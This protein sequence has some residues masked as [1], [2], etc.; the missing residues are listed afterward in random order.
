VQ[1]LIAVPGDPLALTPALS[2]LDHAAAEAAD[3]PSR[4]AGEGGL[5]LQVDVT[6]SPIRSDKGRGPG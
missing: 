4:Q 3:V 5:S 2:V 6:L 1:L